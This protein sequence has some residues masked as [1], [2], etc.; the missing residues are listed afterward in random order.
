VGLNCAGRG[1]IPRSCGDW[2]AGQHMS[3]TVCQ[4]VDCGEVCGGICGG[5]IGGI[6]D[7]GC[8][9]GCVE[10]ALAVWVVGI[11]GE[12]RLPARCCGMGC[13]SVF[14]FLPGSPRSGAF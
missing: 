8:V 3:R 4:G 5:Q 9:M 13:V 2:A 10:R 12:L 14:G 1:R 7:V 11:R 6:R